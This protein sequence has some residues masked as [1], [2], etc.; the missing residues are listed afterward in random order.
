MA[1]QIRRGTLAQLTAI[2]PDLAEPIWTTDT[3]ALYVGDG[4]T[5]GGWPVGGTGYNQSLNTTSSVTFANLTL[6]ASGSITFG[7]STVQTTA[8]TTSFNPFNQTLN[9]SSNVTFAQVSGN[10]VRTIGTGTNSTLLTLIG[11]NIN[12]VDGSNTGTGFSGNHKRIGFT[13]GTGS[14]ADTTVPALVVQGNGANGGYLSLKS[15]RW[16][17]TTTTATQSADVLGSVGFFGALGGG[18]EALAGGD[19]QYIGATIIAT[20][21]NNWTTNNKATNL[22]ISITPSSSSSTVAMVTLNN[23]GTVIASNYDLVLQGSG[24]IKFPDGTRLTTSNPGNPFNQ[25][26]NTTS[27]VTFTDITVSGSTVNTNYDYLTNN[28]IVHSS[29]YQTGLSG[30]GTYTLDQFDANSFRS[31][32]YFVQLKDGSN[33]HVTEISLFHNDTDVYKTEYGFHANNGLLGTFSATIGHLGGDW[34]QLQF[35]PTG[36]TNLS[37]R[38]AKTKLAV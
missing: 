27:S 12:A 3:H 29:Y 26:L 2:T 33:I 25:T 16:S 30:T 4:I 1:L 5:P 22:T 19:A 34:V 18:T 7:D 24:G 14:S 11:N 31:A 17:G 15:F 36:A 8:F 28:G 37:V 9:T 21:A 13:I 38:V 6:G 20:A 23:S 35:T 32:K 10:I